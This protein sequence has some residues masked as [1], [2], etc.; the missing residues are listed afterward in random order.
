MSVNINLIVL[1]KNVW[2]SIDFCWFLLIFV[3]FCW[4]LLIFLKFVEIFHDF[5]W[6]FA[7]RIRIRFIEADPDRDPADQNETD[8]DPKHWK[9]GLYLIS[10]LFYIQPDIRFH[11]PD[12]RISG[13][14]VEQMMPTSNEQTFFRTFS[15]SMN[16]DWNATRIVGRFCWN[17][18]NIYFK[19]KK[20]IS[21][22]SI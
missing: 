3:D 6:F 9:I 11:L 12:N 2:Y 17:F 4:F 5:G 22:F 15:L 8:P 21:L 20:N 16:L 1:K 7:T 10:K 19:K 13:W 18:K 14:T